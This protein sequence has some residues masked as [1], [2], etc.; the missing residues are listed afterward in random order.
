MR[1][2][3]FAGLKSPNDASGEMVLPLRK[4]DGTILD[5]GYKSITE[6]RREMLYYRKFAEK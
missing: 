4:S 3:G 2:T 5:M 6:A 1:A